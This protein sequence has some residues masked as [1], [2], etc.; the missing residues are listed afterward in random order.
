MK[1]KLQNIFIAIIILNA[2]NSLIILPLYNQQQKINISSSYQLINNFMQN[3]L[4][5]I[6][7][8]GNPPQNV[9]L[10]ISEEDIIFSIRKHNCLMQKYYYNKSKSKSFKNLTKGKKT[11][12]RFYESI[13]AEDSFYFYKTDNDNI[14]IKDNVIKVDNFSFVFENEQAQNYKDNNKKFNCAILSL[15]LFRNNIANNDYNFI[16]ELKKLGVIDNHQWTIKYIDNNEKSDNNLEGYLIIGE[17]PHV[18][19]KEKFNILNL[20][21]CLNNMQEKGW[22]LEFRNI[23]IDNDIILTHYMRGIISFSNSYILGTEE[24]KSKI[25]SNFFRDLMK[26]NICFEDNINSHYFIYVCKKGEFN[27]T[28]IKNFPQLNLF[29]AEFNYTFKFSGNDLFLEKN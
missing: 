6:I 5:T 18:Y 22:N 14:K 3:N 28:T 17:Y 20:R 12:P 2:S 15:N 21:S 13:E 16:I 27:E 9:E 4:Y 25:A 24:Y 19:E 10:D 23:T 11:S 1:I 29:H 7:E 26:Q 8:G